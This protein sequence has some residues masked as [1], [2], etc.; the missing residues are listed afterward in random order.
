[1]C[2][3][4]NIGSYEAPSGRELAPAVSHKEAS[5]VTEGERVTMKLIKTPKSRKLLPPLTRDPPKLISF[6]S[7]NPA[8]VPLNAVSVASAPEGGFDTP[9]ISRNT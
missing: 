5:A 7:G 2:F 6:V 1:M 9:N 4:V 3:R 8:A